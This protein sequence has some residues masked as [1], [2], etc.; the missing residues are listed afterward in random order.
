M[1]V[2]RSNGSTDCAEGA[3][4]PQQEPVSSAEL[5]QQQQPVCRVCWAEDDDDDGGSL[6]APCR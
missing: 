4:E 5:S 1:P 2:V 6:I 3:A